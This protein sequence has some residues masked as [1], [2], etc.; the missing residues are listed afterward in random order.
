MIERKAFL[1]PNFNGANFERQSVHEP[2][3]VSPTWRHVPHTIADVRTGS[4]GER[5]KPIKAPTD[6]WHFVVP[7]RCCLCVADRQGTHQPPPQAFT[8][9]LASSTRQSLSIR[10]VRCEIST[11][12]S[13]EEHVWVAVL[14]LLDHW[15]YACHTESPVATRRR[16]SIDAETSENPRVSAAGDDLFTAQ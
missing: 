11:H 14:W 3:S 9:V 15:S 16:S 4:S 5:D 10:C 2:S 1:H 13:S 8:A 12:H 6:A 7:V